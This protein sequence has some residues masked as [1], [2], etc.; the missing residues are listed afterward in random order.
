MSMNNITETKKS[1]TAQ[2]TFTY[3]CKI[4]K[5]KFILA[6]SGLTGTGSTVVAQY[7]TDA[8]SVIEAD[9]VT[10]GTAVWHDADPSYTADAV[11]NAV[12]GATMHWRAG[13]KT[14]GYSSGTII[15]EILQG[16]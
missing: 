16:E 11:R 10:P 2:N 1:I 8:D 12:V 4:Q 5:G 13:V 14:G 3:P 6:I 15:C 9:M 7:S